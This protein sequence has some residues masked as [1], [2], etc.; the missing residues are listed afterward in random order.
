MAWCLSSEE[1][2]T[3]EQMFLEMDKQHTGTITLGQL[4]KVVDD[5]KIADGDSNESCVVSESAAD[6]KINYSEFLAAM[7]S[8]RI[9]AHDDLLQSAFKR[10]DTKQNGYISL[11]DLQQHLGD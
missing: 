7:V 3:V 5:M 9:E 1:R 11:E 8:T 2:K 10:F 4:K 6:E